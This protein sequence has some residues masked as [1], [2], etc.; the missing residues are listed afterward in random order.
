MAV[1]RIHLRGP[2][3]FRMIPQSVTQS[4]ASSTTGTAAMPQDWLTLFGTA[5][6]TVHFRRKFHCPT[7]LGPDEQVMLVFTELRGTGIVR[8]NGHPVGEF[9][10]SGNA[11]EFVIT[12]LLRPFNEILVEIAFDPQEEPDQPGGLFGVVALEIRQD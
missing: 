4:E 8:L 9:A 5:A 7:N 11:V 12:A 6:G 3:D 1:H 10:A 2:W